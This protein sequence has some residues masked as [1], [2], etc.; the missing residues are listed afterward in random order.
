MPPK[1]TPAKERKEKLANFKSYEAQSRLL[2]ALVATLGN[3]RFD[4][5]TI[6][7]FHGGGATA[8][9]MEHK[10]RIVRAQ[11]KFIKRLTEA[12]RDPGDY[13][14]P[15]LKQDAGKTSRLS[16]P[17]AAVVSAATA[18]QQYFGESTPDGLAFQFRGIKK[19][20]DVLKA[21]A[22]KGEDPVG[23]FGA[24]VKGGARAASSVPATP[25]ST[26]RARSTK[27]TASGSGATPTSKRRKAIKIEPEAEFDDDDDSPEADYSEL[28]TTPTKIKPKDQGNAGQLVPR[29][30]WAKPAENPKQPRQ[31]AIAPAP[32]RRVTPRPAAPSY[33]LAPIPGI[34]SSSDLPNGYTD[35]A[36]GFGYNII[37]P[38]TIASASPSVASSPAMGMATARRGSAYS[39]GSYTAASSPGTPNMTYSDTA[40]APTTN[41]GR[42][43][44][45]AHTTTAMADI[46]MVAHNPVSTTNTSSFN[47]NRFSS[48]PSPTPSTQDLNTP[49]ATAS[50]NTMAASTSGVHATATSF[51]QDDDFTPAFTGHAASTGYAT[52]GGNN[53]AYS[54]FD[55][56]EAELANQMDFGGF[57]EQDEEGDGWDA[58]DI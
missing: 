25:S 41:M 20:G 4:Y 8:S 44:P 47:I 18:I 15:S 58:G 32:P 35:P 33:T 40:P 45:S 50:T 55:Q 43:Y 34:G 27:A 19:G 10:F 52:T 42:Q 22:Q 3:H 29:S 31:V 53:R 11:A 37:P 14:V 24:H 6:V 38:T 13:D 48:M 30:A 12:G 16:Q 2:S 28:D 9:S 54:S 46:N 23:A 56:R 1:G 39:S 17:T 36:T 5:Q 51:E 57:E 49:Q 21:A 7:Q 26:K